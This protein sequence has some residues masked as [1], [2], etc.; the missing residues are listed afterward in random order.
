MG[1][2]E[3]LTL[4]YVMERKKVSEFRGCM[5]FGLHKE[6]AA[7]VDLVVNKIDHIHVIY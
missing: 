7:V 6:H 4:S 5:V 1:S 3:I 2:Q